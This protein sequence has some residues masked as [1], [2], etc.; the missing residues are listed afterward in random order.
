MTRDG[1]RQRF[2]DEA[3]A[4]GALELW[5]L[6]KRQAGFELAAFSPWAGRGCTVAALC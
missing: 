6:Q 1:E 3:S 4:L 5:L 2:D